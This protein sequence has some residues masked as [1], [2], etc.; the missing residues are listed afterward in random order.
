MTDKYKEF[1]DWKNKQPDGYINKS[2]FTG[3]EANFAQYMITL[4]DNDP[5][6][7]KMVTEIGSKTE[8][9]KQVY[10]FYKDEKSS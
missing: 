4:I 8:I 1:I 10:T 9:F 7:K 6:L 5:I 2:L 3:S